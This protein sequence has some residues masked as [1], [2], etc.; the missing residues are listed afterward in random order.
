MHGSNGRKP[1]NNGVRV[2]PA[3]GAIDLRRLP[4][5]AQYILTLS[6]VAVVVAAGWIVGRDNPVPAWITA[7]LI[8]FLGWAVLVLFAIVV[9]TRIRRR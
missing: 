7:Y 1:G 8:S 9:V 3:Q 4:S 2:P 5:W 6:V